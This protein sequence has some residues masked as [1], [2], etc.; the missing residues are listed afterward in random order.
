MIKINKTTVAGN[1]SIPRK[2]HQMFICDRQFRSIDDLPAYDES[3]MDN[4]CCMRDAVLSHSIINPEYDYAFYDKH[5]IY[6]YMSNIDCSETQFTHDDVMECYMKIKSNT[7]LCDYTRLFLAYYE[8]G[9]YLDADMF[10]RIPFSTFIES[11]DTWIVY[12]GHQGDLN[13]SVIVCVPGMKL[14]E[15]MIVQAIQ[16]IKTHKPN[17]ALASI[18]GGP[19]LTSIATKMFPELM[20]EL[21]HHKTSPWSCGIPTCDHVDIHG[22]YK[23]GSHVI[24]ILKNDHFG[25]AVQF[26][27]PRYK[28]DLNTLKSTYWKN[29]INIVV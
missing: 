13:N 16:N 8:G 2:I 15:I 23:T 4:I 28:N 19:V 3:S 26:Q 22:Y 20:C 5:D 29:D 11:T 6:Q 14:F 24:K 1:Q 18:A 21:R 9:I 25:G 12:P 27:Y 17:D 10:S 7:L